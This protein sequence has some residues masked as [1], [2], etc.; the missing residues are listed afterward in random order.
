MRRE[1]TKRDKMA[2]TRKR[3]GTSNTMSKQDDNTTNDQNLQEG[4]YHNEH[5]DHLL[6]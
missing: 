6:N 3:M 1:K 2:P 4:N 5:E